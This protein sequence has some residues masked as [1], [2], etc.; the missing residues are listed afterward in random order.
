MGPVSSATT[1][2]PTEVL[3]AQA[4]SEDTGILVAGRRVFSSKRQARL[5]S[6]RGNVGEEG[7]PPATIVSPANDSVILLLLV[8][9]S[10]RDLG[11]LFSQTCLRDG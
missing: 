8:V 11:T 2:S 6:A 9:S 7:V 4:S 10:G 5:E 3:V 1:G